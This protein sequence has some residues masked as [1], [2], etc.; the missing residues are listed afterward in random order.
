MGYAG[1]MI[2]KLANKLLAITHQIYHRFFG[3]F[4]KGV[5]LSDS[6]DHK[7]TN[8]EILDNLDFILKSRGSMNEYLTSC[9]SSS[10][11]ELCLKTSDVILANVTEKTKIGHILFDVAW[12]EFPRVLDTFEAIGGNIFLTDKGPDAA[13]LP[14]YL[15]DEKVILAR[16]SA[17]NCGCSDIDECAIEAHNC[18][19][20]SSCV[21]EYA[22]YACECNK[23]FFS[24]SGECHDVDEC[25]NDPCPLHS[26]CTNTLGSFDCLCDAGFV[27]DDGELSCLDVDECSFRV[28][29]CLAD[30]KCSNEIGSFSCEMERNTNFDECQL[31][32]ALKILL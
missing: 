9:S 8:V 24:E 29:V 13:G 10:K 28:S 21:N 6:A 11:A 25:Q 14:V 15:D 3:T 23:G 22:G 26:E 27:M 4:P 5:D 17:G 20:H 18:P 31:G 1:K 19:E 2:N 16:K 12:D 30:E 32:T 7:I